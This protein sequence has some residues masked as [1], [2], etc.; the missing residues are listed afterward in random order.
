MWLSRLGLK[1]TWA[2][3]WSGPR[4]PDNEAPIYRQLGDRWPCKGNL[5]QAGKSAWK[6]WENGQFMGKPLENPWISPLYPKVIKLWLPEGTQMYSYGHLWVI[7]GYFYGIIHSINGII[8]ICTI[9]TDPVV[10]SES[11]WDCGVIWYHLEGFL[12][13]LRQ[14]LDP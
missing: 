3:I 8:S 6:P 14:C 13:L 1:S 11:K 2:K 12:Y 4:W 7:T 10:P 5:K 9:P